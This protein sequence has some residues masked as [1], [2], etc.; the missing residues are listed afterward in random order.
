MDP[1]TTCSVAIGSTFG[2]ICLF[3][4]CCFYFNCSE[5]NRVRPTQESII[6]KPPDYQEIATS[7]LSTPSESTELPPPPVYQET[8]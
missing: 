1:T 8:E 5:P 6:D 7:V 4:I 3:A 2:G